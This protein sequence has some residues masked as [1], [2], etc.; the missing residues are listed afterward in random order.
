MA[1]S[2]NTNCVICLEP[3]SIDTGMT[4]C[5]HMF[6]KKCILHWC[7]ECSACPLCRKE[8][9]KI[10]IFYR[11]F[12]MGEDIPVFP[13]K[14]KISNENNFEPD[15][16][17]LPDSDFEVPDDYVDLIVSSQEDAFQKNGEL[18]YSEYEGIGWN[19]GTRRSNRPIHDQNN[20]VEQSL[21]MFRL[22]LHQEK[23][24]K[25]DAERIKDGIKFLFS[26]VEKFVNSGKIDHS[27]SNEI[28]EEVSKQIE[29]G[30]GTVKNEQ[31]KKMVDI[32]L[33]KNPID[34]IPRMR[35]P[36]VPVGHNQRFH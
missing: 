26:Y 16:L 10:R 20:E 5:G 21:A 29:K 18:Y 6:C 4:N 7:E 19:N 3:F 23:Q 24:K 33:I 12:Y 14:Q 13:K 27:E 15:D 25:S 30:K 28:I 1:Q 34:K 17:I 8:M 11:S 9:T 35:R 22:K 36:R 2:S 32:K 31:I